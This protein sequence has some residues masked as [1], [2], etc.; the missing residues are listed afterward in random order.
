M[1]RTVSNLCDG[2]WNVY[3]HKIC[4][5]IKRTAFNRFDRAWQ[6]NTHKTCTLIKRT[7]LNRYDGVGDGNFHKPCTPSKS[8][9]S[10]RCDGV[11]DRNTRKSCAIIKPMVT[12]PC[13]G[14]RNGNTRKPFA[15]RKRTVSNRCDYPCNPVR[16][17]FFRYGNVSFISSINT[18]VFENIR[19]FT[20][21]FRQY[22]VSD[23]VYHK[24]IC[25]ALPRHYQCR[26]KQDGLNYQLFHDVKFFRN[27]LFV[28]Q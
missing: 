14:V 27:S 7:G 19:N 2:T 10:N 28:L 21:S 17:Y 16:C 1:K 3:T 12:N 22:V 26:R 20:R 18:F 13:N 6:V 15:V 9:V 23:A 5:T 11:R 4:T 8:T 24:I 25:Q